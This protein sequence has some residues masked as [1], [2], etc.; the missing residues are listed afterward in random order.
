MAGNRKAAE[1][2]IVSNIMRITGDSYNRDRY[3]KYFQSLSDKE[4]ED[5]INDL[6]TGDKFLTVQVPNFSDSKL[7]VENNIKIAN[8]LKY[9]FFQRLWIGPTA[10][11]PRYLSPVEYLVIDLPLRRVSQMLI[12]KISTAEHSRSI[13]TYS[14]QVAGDSKTSKISYPELQLAATLNLD[15][16]LV[17]LI[18]YRG[19]DIRGGFALDAMLKKYGT[20]S[21]ATLGKYSSGVESTKTL[22]IFLNCCHL[23][24]TL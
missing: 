23:K 18:K 13:D 9:S 21:M 15:N 24:S 2:F 22:K 14:G 20:A 17:E 8:S 5:Y 19:G 1:D 3:I 12:K 16:S 6:E 10:G 7:S 4:F 11:M